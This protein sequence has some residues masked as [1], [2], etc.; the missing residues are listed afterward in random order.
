MRVGQVGLIPRGVQPDR[1]GISTPKRLEAGYLSLM[2]PQGVFV[3][4]SMTG[5][6]GCCDISN[7][8]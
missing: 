3:E 5:V 1:Q 7:N 6:G 2:H 8:V 4:A